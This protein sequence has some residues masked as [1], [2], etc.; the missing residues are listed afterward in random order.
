MRIVYLRLYFFHKQVMFEFVQDIDER[1]KHEH[2]LS[3]SIYAPVSASDPVRD[4]LTC[5]ADPLQIDYDDF[6]QYSFWTKISGMPVVLFQEVNKDAWKRNGC[7][8]IMVLRNL[9]L[10]PDVRAY[11]LLSMDWALSFCKDLFNQRDATL[12]IEVVGHD[13]ITSR[14]SFEVNSTLMS[15]VTGKGQQGMYQLTIFF[16]RSSSITMRPLQ[17]LISM[18]HEPGTIN[19]D[20]LPENDPDMETLRTMAEVIKFLQSDWNLPSPVCHVETVWK[21]ARPMTPLERS[22]LRSKYYKK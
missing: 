17:V 13:G 1:F 7:P 4:I 11:R 15:H 21:Q 14:F 10:F 16:S 18:L 5:V 19:S 6:P 20:L 3:S 22:N 12:I 8:A 2:H 9:P